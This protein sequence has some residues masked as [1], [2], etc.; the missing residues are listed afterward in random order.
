MPLTPA[1]ASSTPVVASKAVNVLGTRRVHRSMAAPPPA[2]AATVASTMKSE[3]LANVLPKGQEN[4][5]AEHSDAGDGDYR[6]Q[7]REQ[8]VFKQVLAFVSK[9]QAANCR[10]HLHHVVTLFA[11]RGAAKI[12]APRFNHRLAER[13]FSRPPAARAQRRCGRRSR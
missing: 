8:S 7:R 2:P 4:R 5:V 11:K 9:P 6:D 10:D 1:A 13:S 12:A 3:G